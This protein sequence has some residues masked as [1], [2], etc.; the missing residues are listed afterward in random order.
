MRTEL[1]ITEVGK[2]REGAEKNEVGISCYVLA[3]LS[4]TRTAETETDYT[5]E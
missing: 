5:S 1:S 3:I 2:I 4:W